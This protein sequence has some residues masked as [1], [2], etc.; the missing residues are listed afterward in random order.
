MKWVSLV[1]VTRD[2]RWTQGI[3]NWQPRNGVRSRDRVDGE[4]TLYS[5]NVCC[6]VEQTKTKRN[7]NLTPIFVCLF[8]WSLNV[9]VNN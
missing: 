8:V 2:N 1:T 3:P 6:G 4:M 9:L 5:I 7:G